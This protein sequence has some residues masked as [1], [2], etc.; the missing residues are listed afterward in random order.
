LKSKEVEIE[1][2][3]GDSFEPKDIPPRRISKVAG[4]NNLNREGADK[5]P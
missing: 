5:V 3:K 2:R 4:G 1:S